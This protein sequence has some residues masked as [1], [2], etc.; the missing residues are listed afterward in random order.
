M[1]K[2]NLSKVEIAG[3]KSIREATL[4]LR[5]LNLLIGANGAGKS[6]LV[7]AFGLLN[8]MVGQRLQ[9]RVAKVGGAASLLH[10]GPK[11]TNQ[12]RLHLTFGQNAYEARLEHAQDD[13]LFFAE[14]TCYFQDQGF[15]RPYRKALGGGH[16]ESLLVERAKVP[17]IPKYVLAAMRSWTVY[18]F[19]DTSPE[20]AVKRKG[21][22]D[23]NE[24]LRPDASNLAAFLYRLQRSHQSHYRLIVG[25]IRQVAPFFDDFR[26]RPDR[27]RPGEIHIEWAEKDS[28]TYFNAHAL[29]DGTLRFM[30]LATL[31]LQPRL[32]SLILIDEPELGLHPYAVTQLAALFKSASTQAQ[33]LAATQSVTLMNQFEPDDVVVVD[34]A[35]GQSTF[36]RIAASEIEN[37]VDSY[38][39]G[40]LW[41]KNVLGGRPQR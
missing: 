24:R 26:L 9:V 5:Q 1:A 34:R 23:D 28:D 30:C 22:I 27:L 11:H 31:L 39:L 36:R 35:D 18:H 12:I 37:W 32:P 41:E 38:A 3:F 21:P 19:H 8:Q 4:E 13:S 40:D 15:P 7:S 10:N 2:T 20:A 6:N 16:K 25:A 29:S 33:I 17:G 14:E